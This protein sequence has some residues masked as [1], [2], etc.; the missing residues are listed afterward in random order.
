MRLLRFAAALA[1]LGVS[2]GRRG[3][4]RTQGAQ[5][6]DDDGPF[7][8]AGANEVYGS[9]YVQKT[10]ACPRA[11]HDTLPVLIASCIGRCLFPVVHD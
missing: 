11:N 8:F 5:F 10:V 2:Y 9:C 6:V 7:R 1:V 4:V 3:F